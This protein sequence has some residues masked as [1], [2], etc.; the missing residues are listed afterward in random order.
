MNKSYPSLIEIPLFE[1]SGDTLQCA[2]PWMSIKD[3]MYDFLRLQSL[4]ISY[5]STSCTANCSRTCAITVPG[6]TF[7]TSAR[8]RQPWH[9]GISRFSDI[10]WPVAWS[11]LHRK[12]YEYF[13]DEVPSTNTGVYQDSTVFLSNDTIRLRESVK[14]QLILMLVGTADTLLMFIFR[15]YGRE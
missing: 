4:I 1:R 9:P 11:I 7:T 10:A 6:S 15:I 2:L 5:W 3:L 13:P 8:I 14:S 12:R